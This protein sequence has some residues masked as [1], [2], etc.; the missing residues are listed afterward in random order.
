MYSF[1]LSNGP[2]F[3]FYLLVMSSPAEHKG[4][5]EHRW[6]NTLIDDGKPTSQIGRHFEL[7]ENKPQEYIKQ[8]YFYLLDN[9]SSEQKS[10]ILLVKN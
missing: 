4:S 6:G 3:L 1:V 9:H 8:L 10:G 5:K 2:Q 7:G